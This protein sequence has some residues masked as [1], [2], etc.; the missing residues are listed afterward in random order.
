MHKNQEIVCGIWQK[1]KPNK[2]CLMVTRTYFN[3]WIYQLFELNYYQNYL[4]V[5]CEDGNEWGDWEDLH[6]DEYFVIEYYK[7]SKHSG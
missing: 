5:I 4:A 1:E 6:A 7:D 3:R 2:P